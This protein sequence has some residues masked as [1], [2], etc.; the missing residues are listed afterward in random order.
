MGKERILA[1]SISK[2]NHDAVGAYSWE[3]ENGRDEET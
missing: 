3:K 1:I 2:S